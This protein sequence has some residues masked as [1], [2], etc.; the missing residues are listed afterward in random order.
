MKFNKRSNYK[1]KNCKQKNNLFI[2]CMLP[3]LEVINWSYTWVYHILPG[4]LYF[5]K[6]IL[7]QCPCKLFLWA[8]FLF[9]IGSKLSKKYEC[10]GWMIYVKQYLNIF[11]FLFVAQVLPETWK[12][13]FSKIYRL[14]CINKW[15]RKLHLAKLMLQIGFA[16][17]G[18]KFIVNKRIQNMQI[19]T[20]KSKTCASV[21]QATLWWDGGFVYGSETLFVSIHLEPL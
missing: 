19:C 7:H 18:V 17:I 3:I 15:R 2:R 4:P 6:H 5:P 20:R 1:F 13:T 12:M 8:Q 14:L 16:Y 11:V 10:K 21:L 9:L